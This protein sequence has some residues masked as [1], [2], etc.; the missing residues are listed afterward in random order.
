MR[1]L[2]SS[3]V[4][5]FWSMIGIRTTY[6]LFAVVCLLWVPIRTGIPPYGTFS[7]QSDLLFNAFAQWDST[8]FHRIAE[9]G[10]DVEQTAA[11]FPLYPL[12]VRA[13]AA[14]LGSIIVAGVVVS[15]VSAGV[16]A[17]CFVRIAQ[18]AAPRSADDAFLLLAL[19]PIAF[20]FTAVYSDGLFFALA[21]AGFLA[22]L[23]QRS[24]LAGVLGGLAVATRLMG[25]ALLHAF[26]VLL[27]P[28]R[29]VAR[30]WLRV[31]PTLVC[32]PGALLVYAIYLHEH[33]HDAFAFVHAQRV[34]WLRH[35]PTLGPIGGLWNA[36]KS[37]EQGAAE[38]IRHLPARQG[39]PGGYGMPEQWAI[40]NLTQLLLLLAAFWL[41]WV[42]WKRLGPAYGLYSL[43]TLL[44][45]LSSVADVVPLVSI[46]RFLLSDFP[47]FIALAG[48]VE[49]RPRLRLGVLIAFGSVGAVAAVAFSHH[50]WVA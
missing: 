7:A 10:Y 8:W 49:S 32:M 13:L 33:F 5:P 31:V 15:L 9:H 25:L 1:W 28:K 21:A 40:W 23:R 34:F 42:A 38:L 12:V 26:L 22:A 47:L 2:R 24:I 45:L 41:T 6:W 37:G 30:N 20:I 43:G 17:V 27:W 46:P 39:A 50:V 4:R 3:V 14:V 19:Y 44:I 29:P 18:L 16:G 36:L 11:F 35:T 48:I